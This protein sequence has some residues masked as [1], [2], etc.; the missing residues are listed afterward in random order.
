MSKDKKHVYETKFNDK[1]LK[2]LNRAAVLLKLDGIEDVFKVAL[3]KVCSYAE[4]YNRGNTKVI[5]CLPELAKLMEDNP[6][7]I[8]ALCE[9]GVVEWLTPFVLGKSRQGAEVLEAH[10]QSG[11]ADQR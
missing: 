5:Y 9:E 7:F 6:E 4:A 8:E 3:E 10:G 2:T 1:G 11:D